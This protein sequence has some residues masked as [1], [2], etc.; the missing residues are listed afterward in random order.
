MAFQVEPSG[1]PTVHFCGLRIWIHGRESPDSDDEWDGNWLRVTANCAAAGASV[2]STGS[3]LDTVSFARWEQ[4]L[5][6]LYETLSGE[7]MLSASEPELVVQVQSTDRVGH[8]RVR[9]KIT[10]VLVNQDHRFDFSAD[11]SYL[12]PVIQ[13]CQN[14]L[15][16]YPVRRPERRGLP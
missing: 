16:E 6:R 15:A 10:P 5:R 7:A 4:S 12:P 1:P 2:W 13:Q 8:L 9:V 3:F 14:L 11:Q